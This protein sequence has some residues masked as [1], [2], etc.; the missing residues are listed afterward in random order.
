[1]APETVCNIDST[2][3]TSQFV[4]LFVICICVLKLGICFTFDQQISQHQSENTLW[5]LKNPLDD[6]RQQQL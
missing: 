6:K 4:R 1:M 3:F 5:F 2:I